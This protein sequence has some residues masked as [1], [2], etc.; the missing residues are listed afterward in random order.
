M[1]SKQK[2]MNP[3]C[4]PEVGVATG[5]QGDDM[6]LYAW[7]RSQAFSHF[8]SP[9]R[10]LPLMICFQFPQLTHS[11]CDQNAVFFITSWKW[12]APETS[13]YLSCD[14]RKNSIS[15]KETGLVLFKVVNYAPFPNLSETCKG[16][17][18]EKKQQKIKEALMGCCPSKES[19][20]T[21]G[22]ASAAEANVTPINPN[23]LKEIGYVVRM[24]M[25]L[26]SY[27]YTRRENIF[28]NL[29]LCHLLLYMVQPE[30]WSFHGHRYHIVRR[31]STS[32]GL[33]AD[34]LFNMV[35]AV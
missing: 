24:R 12:R 31:L 27:A 4:L 28:N 32:V 8:V 26:Y 16:K 18:K 33:W 19:G 6:C 5:F 30:T 14:A 17:C 13:D 25:R 9:L 1:N 21:F 10:M 23:V 3:I 20:C 22:A 15:S 34:K 7:L 29:C 2:T 11:R 35:I